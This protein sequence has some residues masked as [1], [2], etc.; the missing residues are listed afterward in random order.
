M[1]GVC[2]SGTCLSSRLPRGDASGPPRHANRSSCSNVQVTLG[3]FEAMIEKNPKDLPLFAPS[4]LK[5][6]DLILGSN[7]LTL[8]ESSLPVFEAFCSNHDA[9]S[10]FADQAYL[11]QYESVVRQYAALA[12]TRGSP[13]KG[14][15]SAPVAMRWRNVGLEAIRSVAS[16]DA[17]SSVS[18]RQYDVIVPMILENLWTDNEDFLEVLLMRAQLEEKVDAER[19]LRRRTSIATVRTADTAGDTNPIALSGTAMDVDKLAEEEVG[20]LAMQCLKL[21]FV[22]PNRSQIH[23]ATVALLK[24]IEERI[25]QN[26]T[27][28]KQIPKTEKDA[29]WAIKMFGL[30]SRWAPV[31]DRYIIL[32]TAMDTMAKMK[33]A[34][35]TLTQHI[36]LTAMAGSLLR[37]DVNLIGL[38]V[39][40]VLH[41]LVQHIKKLVQLPGDPSG[42]PGVGILPGQPDPRSPTTIAAADADANVANL[43]KELLGRLQHCIGDLATHVYY[44][45]Q[46]S[47]MIGAILLRLKP[48]RSNSTANSS[49]PGEKADDM[50]PSATN[51]ID[52]IDSLFSLTVAKTAALRA[53]KAILLVANPRTKV[54]GNQNLSRNKV[55]IQCWEGTH[56][57]LRDPDGQVRKAYADALLTW[58]ERETVR[59]DSMARDENAPRERPKPGKEPGSASM[60]KR[61]VSNASN[62][63]SKPVKMPRSHFIALLHVAIYDNALQYV[64]Y[65]TD[66]VL[67]HVILAK[68]VDK[69]GV[70]AVR[71]GLPMVFQLQEAIQ[72]AD[73][74]LAKVRIGSLVHGYFWVLTEKF[75]FE[76]S[77]VGRAI[78]N[79]IIRRRSKHFWVEGVHVPA[80][81]LELVGTPGMSRPQ[82]KMPMHEVESEALLPF[83]DRISL[84]ECICTA[85]REAGALSPPQSPSASPGRTLAH[86]ILAST[87]SSVPGGQIEDEIPSQYREQMLTDWSREAVM[88]AVSAGSK[89]ASLAGSKAGT[90]GTVPRNNRLTVNGVN[91]LP[92]SGAASPYGSTR[93]LRPAS[94]PVAGLGL[95]APV[96]KLRKTS[97]RSAL[98]PS[99]VSSSASRGGFVTGV[100][101]LKM[102]LSGQ[103]QTRAPQF[104]KTA[105]GGDDSSSDSMVSYDMP[106]SEFSYATNSN[107]HREG[108][109]SVTRETSSVSP[110]GMM[111]RSVSIE[112]KGSLGP[113]TSN[114]PHEPIPS[115]VP[116]EDEAADTNGQEDVPP[117]PPIPS[118]LV[119]SQAPLMRPMSSRRREMGSRAG[120]S[121]A[122]SG[123]S[124]S[125]DEAPPLDLTAM[126]RGIDSGRGD[127]G[128]SGGIGGVSRPPY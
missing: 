75:D 116:E 19:L 121:S 10:L 47:D 108:G 62:R 30:V 36:A 12:S 107:A 78:H 6:L 29:G 128:G 27:V 3:I 57:L 118:P 61:A 102:V 90:T 66:I 76:A 68:L 84:V 97:V 120:E 53:V 48:A 124:S 11:R 17:L 106:P 69:L 119:G 4:V 32:V 41:S 100:E 38:S 86:P 51:S 122:L 16:S 96:S 94:Q 105:A 81:L 73:T 28:V 8:V 127:V 26:E 123:R 103:A 126:L 89:S 42:T 85:Y 83:D 113:L 77:V 31:Q 49:P 34:D 92:A 110:S 5:I 59:A 15:V 45:D 99:P 88:L 60:A 20:V 18:G 39:M 72:E 58:L 50:A 82:P 65:E 46:I 64:D 2:A 111:K 93:D 112:R 114:P 117:V 71:C 54:S 24:F 125:F 63:D 40:D 37:S 55:P 9:S 67:L 101:Q 70:N 25:N 23:A 35:D 115:L 52:A 21:I 80:P 33:L 79:E 22:A 14:P 7:D 95:V 98:S 109:L 1:F 104:S 13:G 87:L 91:G 74:P 43:R 56:W 44:A